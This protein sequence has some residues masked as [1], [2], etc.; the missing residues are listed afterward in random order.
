MLR[1]RSWGKLTGFAW[2]PPDQQQPPG[3]EQVCWWWFPALLQLLH[4]HHPC[5]SILDT[6]L[7]VCEQLPVEAHLLSGQTVTRCSDCSTKRPRQGDGDSTYH[8][9][10]FKTIKPYSY[11]KQNIFHGNLNSK[12]IIRYIH[13]TLHKVSKNPFWR[14][15]LLLSGLKLCSPSPLAI[16]AKPFQIKT[17]P[18]NFCYLP[19][20]YGESFE[21]FIEV[22]IFQVYLDV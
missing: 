2:L 21:T 18:P 15:L 3:V 12:H 6:R 13:Y 1:K 10:P 9:G 8:Q 22:C 5:L 19:A 7:P 16:P 20:K 11:W 4:C 14:S 17:I